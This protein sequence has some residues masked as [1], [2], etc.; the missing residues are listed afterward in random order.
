VIA[1]LPPGAL[2]VRQQGSYALSD[3]LHL[4]TLP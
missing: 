2:R 4:T 1:A 3:P